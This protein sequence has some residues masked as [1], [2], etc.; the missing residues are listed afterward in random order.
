M[1]FICFWQESCI[2]TRAF[3]TT[4]VYSFLK[5]Y[6]KKAIQSVVSAGGANGDTN[7]W[8]KMVN[9]E[10]AKKVPDHNRLR[11]IGEHCIYK[12]VNIKVML[13]KNLRSADS[14]A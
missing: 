6:L 8:M 10:L 7:N 13:E 3:D 2:V 14:A 1:F 4:F 11:N 12:A 9:S 5:Q